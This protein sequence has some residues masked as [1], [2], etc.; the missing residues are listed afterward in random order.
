SFSP[1]LTYTDGTSTL[2]LTV[3]N[4]DELAEKSGWAF[5]DTLPDGLVVADPANVGATCDATVGASGSVITVEDGTLAAGETSCEITVDVTSSEV[6][7]YDSSAENISDVV[8]IGLPGLA[9][10]EFQA[11]DFGDAPAS[12]GTL[13]VDN[14]PFH[15]IPDYDE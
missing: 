8:G 4:T 5:T 14:G 15:L 7:S 10:V 13:A 3:T 12:Y 9:T 2:T 11:R 1:E 6:G